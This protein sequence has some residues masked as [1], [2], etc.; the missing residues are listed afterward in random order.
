[1]AKQADAHLR[2]QAENTKLPQE[3][4]VQEAMRIVLGERN[5]AYGDPAEDYA[6]TAKIWSGLLASKLKADIT[7][8]EAIAMMIGV[9]LSRE[10]HGH[11]RDNLVDAHGYL[12]CMQW[13]QTG[14]KPQA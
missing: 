9:K 11:K 8:T 5:A 3:S 2:E 12:L 1:M 10:M 6:K 7:P 13:V 14:H 4:Y